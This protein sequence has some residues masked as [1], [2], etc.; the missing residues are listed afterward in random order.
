MSD[1]VPKLLEVKALS[2]FRLWLR[3][4]DGAQG[5]LDLSGLAGRGVFSV[6]DAPGVFESVKLE[7]H[8][9]PSWGDEVDL[10]P[11]ALYLRLTGKAAE[12]VFPVLMKAAVDA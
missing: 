5:E 1:T 10:C 3:Y 4:E 8:G 6:W 2:D 7:P 12:E 11:D 9:A